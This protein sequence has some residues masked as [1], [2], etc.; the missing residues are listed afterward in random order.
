MSCRRTRAAAIL[1]LAVV[2]SLGLAAGAQAAKAKR[3]G[4]EIEIEGTRYTP[5]TNTLTFVG[6][7]SSPKTKCEKRREVTIHY[8]GPA[9]PDDVA[10]GLTD[11]TGDF[12]LGVS[13]SGLPGGEFVAEVARRKIKKGD[14]K[15]VC[16]AATSSTFILD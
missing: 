4:T 15:L 12:E 6:D 8:N 10:E 9:P 1:G 16:K 5:S 7:V 14:T 2:L 11:H 13:N 3:V